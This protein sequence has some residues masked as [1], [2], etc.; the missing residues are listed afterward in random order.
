MSPLSKDVSLI[1]HSYL[2]SYFSMAGCN[3]SSEWIIEG[4]RLIPLMPRL[5]PQTA[6]TVAANNFATMQ[7]EKNMAMP[8]PSKT[9]NKTGMYQNNDKKS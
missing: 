7:A 2:H 4:R 1:G 8:S 5:V 3:V 9:G 6:F